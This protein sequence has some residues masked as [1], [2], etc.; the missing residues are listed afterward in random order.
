MKNGHA[1]LKGDVLTFEKPIL[2]SGVYSPREVA[3]YVGTN[4]QSILRWTRGSGS[5]EPLWQNYYYALEDDSELN[6]QD[7]MEIR[8]VAKF[9]KEGLSMQSIRYA[10]NLARETFKT[11]YPLS[12]E[13]FKTDGQQIWVQ[14]LNEENLTSLSKK[15]PLQK[16]FKEIILPSLVDA[17][18]ENGRPSIWRPAIGENVVVLDPNRSFG[19]SV[20]D[21]FGISTSV[22]AEEYMEFENVDYL[23]KIYEIPKDL[24]ISAINFEFIL[25]C[26]NPI[27]PQFAA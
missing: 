5:S 7:L 13:A 1:I 9:R 20:V 24:V 14:A 4:V 26:K 19:A 12:H 22:L 17:E 27:R 3:R 8:V 23:S 6:F 2:G 11:D 25:D 10:I 21:D 16:S 18:F 15:Y